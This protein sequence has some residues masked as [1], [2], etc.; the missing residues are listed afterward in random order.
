[1]AIN[2]YPYF[3]EGTFENYPNPYANEPNP[4]AGSEAFGRTVEDAYEG[5]HSLLLKYGSAGGHYDQDYKLFFSFRGPFYLV[6]LEPGKKYRVS[7]KVKTPA[8]ADGGGQLGTDEVKIFLARNYDGGDGG[9]VT[10]VLP[11][12]TIYT[13][14]NGDVLR[15]VT[16]GQIKGLG[17]AEVSFEFTEPAD[18][19]PGQRV[20]FGITVSASQ[21][22]T[23][24]VLDVP[25]GN[26]VYNNG[27]LF[28]DDLRLEEVTTCDLALGSPAYTKTDETAEGANDGTITINAT[29]SYAIQYSRLKVITA[30]DAEITVDSDLITVDQTHPTDAFQ[31]S[32]L[33]SGLP[34]GLYEI[35]VRD[36]NGCE[37]VITN[38]PILA[39]NPP[40]PPPPPPPVGTLEINAAPVNKYNFISWFAANGKADFG[41]LTLTNCFWDLPNAYQINK[42]KHK[43]FPVVVND[44]QFSFYLNFT[45]DY[46]YPNFSSLRLDLVTQYGAVQNGVGVL[47]RVFQAD[48]VKYFIY[49]NVTLTGIAPG[50]YRLM[51]TD[52]STPDPYDVLFISQEIEIMS[53]T[54]APAFTA[55]FRWRCSSSIYRFLYSEITDFYQQIRL[56]VNAFDGESLDG[57]IEQYRAVTSGKLRNVSFDLDKFIV[58]ETY[59][60]DK[61]AHRAME[62]FQANDLIFINGVAY[63]VK[64]IYKWPRAI[65]ATTSKGTL[66]LYEQEFS[67]IN[68]YGNPN[69]IT[70]E[71]PIL[72]GDGG[73]AIK[74]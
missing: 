13:M 8:S 12:A 62:V 26:D 2:L 64:S 42:V 17:W 73:G 5:T 20:P 70:V 15:V 57:R 25:F 23:S 65:S 48:G 66:E 31:N 24:P 53:A 58:L 14:A 61:L 39:F 56:R 63:L 32:N 18:G 51:I 67:T 54:E 34:P 21:I 11:D 49:A 1:M 41:A 19:I 10:T 33:F 16:V 71:D 9:V 38:I 40:A 27:K 55:R 60:F 4:A 22:N 30:D 50:Y 29:S 47:Q 36:L 37:Q 72:L 28:I 6:V 35:T 3:D 44:E 7:C 52:T 46:N 68:R 59:F 69:A 45:A 43:H 74:L